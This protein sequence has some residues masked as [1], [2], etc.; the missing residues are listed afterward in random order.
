MF[1]SNVRYLCQKFQTQVEC[2]CQIFQM[3]QNFQLKCSEHVSIVHVTCSKYMANAFIKRS[4]HTSNLNVKCL[5]QMFQIHIRRQQ[6]ML[7]T[8]DKS[9]CRNVP[10]RFEQWSCSLPHFHLYARCSANTISSAVFAQMRRQTHASTSMYRLSRSCT[11]TQTRTHARQKGGRQSSMS[12][13]CHLATRSRQQISLS[14]QLHQS[15][16]DSDT[17]T[18]TPLHEQRP[19]RRQDW[20]ACAKH[21]EGPY[22]I[23]RSALH[24]PAFPA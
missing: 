19:C 16:I 15:K 24:Q 4:K 8:E 1:T 20:R 2:S 17:H 21:Y 6:Q 12:V 10:T 22:S 7:H 11:K 13:N 18:C 5:R 9:L 3:C 23:Q 14:Q